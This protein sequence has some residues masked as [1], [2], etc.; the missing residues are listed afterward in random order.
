M[1]VGRV[2]SG[3]IEGEGGR[4]IVLRTPPI[5]GNVKQM[6]FDVYQVFGSI[7]FNKH[8]FFSESVGLKPHPH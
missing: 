5:V 6:C 4:S 7:L 3:E 1:V 8:I 2:A